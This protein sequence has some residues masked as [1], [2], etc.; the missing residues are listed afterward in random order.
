MPPGL[1]LT[2]GGCFRTL[3]VFNPLLKINDDTQGTAPLP[4]L[5]RRTIENGNLALLVAARWIELR[6]TYDNGLSRKVLIEVGAAARA[7]LERIL[8][9]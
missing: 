1:P 4:G 5:V 2:P 9:I 7:V 8:D 3:T 6:L